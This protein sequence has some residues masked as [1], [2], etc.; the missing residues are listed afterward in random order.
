MTLPYVRIRK[1]SHFLYFSAVFCLKFLLKSLTRTANL[2]INQRKL[3][4]EV[5]ALCCAAQEV[6]QEQGIDSFH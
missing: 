5:A 4:S 2:R 6:G 3:N 1:Y